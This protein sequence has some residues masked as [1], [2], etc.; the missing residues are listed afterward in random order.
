MSRHNY[1]V[2]VPVLSF[3]MSRGFTFVHCPFVFSQLWLEV[4]NGDEELE[5]NWDRPTRVHLPP[6]S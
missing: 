2:A 3:L 5:M 6:L 4:V 1:V